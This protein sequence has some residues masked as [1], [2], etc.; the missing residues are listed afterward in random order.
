MKIVLLSVP[1][2][3]HGVTFL[4]TLTSS[5]KLTFMPSFS[6]AHIWLAN[7]SSFFTMPL[8]PHLLD[9]FFFLQTSSY[10]VVQADLGLLSSSASWILELQV[11]TTMPCKPHLL[12][13]YQLT[14]SPLKYDKLSLSYWLVMITK[15]EHFWKFLLKCLLY[16][17]H[18]NTI[19]FC[20]RKFYYIIDLSPTKEGNCE[21]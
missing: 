10:Y 15:K 3:G 5:P 2:W 18:T 9:S 4:L 13:S 21:V 6:G 16:L 1:H 8:K 20:L 17:R 11:C 7:P 14:N 12:I 19:F